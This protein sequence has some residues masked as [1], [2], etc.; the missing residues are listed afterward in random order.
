MMI[1]PLSGIT[2]G[3]LLPLIKP[4]I[5]LMKILYRDT[6]I[7]G[8]ALDSYT[9][10]EQFIDAPADFN[11]NRMADYRYVDGV[12]I[13][14]RPPLTPLAF[15]RRFTVEERIT[16]CASTDPII[17]DFIALA[18]LAQDILLDDPD[19]IMGV[20]YLEQQGLIA[21]GRAAEILTP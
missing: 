6:T 13:L 21:E 2:T 12:L 9:G 10:Q 15:L 20:G 5:K 1:T 11:I 4:C 7:I 8:A 18:N 3:K 17:M 19:T 16:I 14:T